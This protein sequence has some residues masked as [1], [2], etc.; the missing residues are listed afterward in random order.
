[1][2]FKSSRKS[3]MSKISGILSMI[4]LLTLLSS[5]GQDYNSNSGDEDLGGGRP[6]ATEDCSE[7][8]G[9][10]SCAAVKVIQSRC[11]GC[12]AEWKK[13]KTDAEWAASGLISAGASAS[14]KLFTRLINSGGDMPL[15]GSGLP[16][17]E[18]ATIKNW[19][20]GI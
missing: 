17:D 13:Y 11:F 18:Y 16:D 20:D 3:N 1:M 2:K 4:S 7:P 15:G 10:R 9:A 19:I 8:K 6:V 12:H 14:S 5:C